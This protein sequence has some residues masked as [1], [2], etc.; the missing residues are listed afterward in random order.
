MP[1]HSLINKP[2]KIREKE[3]RDARP[4]R[5]W[6]L[7][8]REGARKT[9]KFLFCIVLSAIIAIIYQKNAESCPSQQP[10]L[11]CVANRHCAYI[12]KTTNRSFLDHLPFMSE[13]NMCVHRSDFPKGLLTLTESGTNLINKIFRSVNTVINSKN[14]N[15]LLADFRYEFD[16]IVFWGVTRQEVGLWFLLWILSGS[17]WAL[18][19]MGDHKTIFDWIEPSYVGEDNIGEDGKVLEEPAPNI[20]LSLEELR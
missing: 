9:V 1:A 7:K 20:P 2:D 8:Y 5:H 3:E 13:N 6:C 12:R 16:T 19:T 14:K 4:K 11:L 18:Q 10:Y 17:M 15:D